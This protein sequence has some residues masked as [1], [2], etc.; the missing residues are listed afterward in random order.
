MYVV[1]L[2]VVSDSSST[3]RA[4]A[5]FPSPE[6]LPVP[7]IEPTSPV[8]LALQADS[9]PLSHLGSP[10]SSVLVCI[11]YTVLS[12]N[13]IGAEN[14]CVSRPVCLWIQLWCKVGGPGD[15]AVSRTAL[16]P[17]S[18]WGLFIQPACYWVTRPSSSKAVLWANSSGARWLLRESPWLHS[19]PFQPIRALTSWRGGALALQEGARVPASPSSPPPLGWPAPQALPYSWGG[20]FSCRAQGWEGKPHFW[21]S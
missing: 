20:S 9:L 5:L 19:R 7:G 17:F 11:N 18:S 14:F 21:L 3:Q 10:V 8:A 16:N 15:R 13:E 2:S 12:K 1:R 4:V 6:D